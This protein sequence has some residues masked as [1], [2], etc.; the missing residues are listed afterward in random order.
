MGNFVNVFFVVFAVLLWLLIIIRLIYT[1]FAKVKSVNAK[2][3]DKYKTSSHSFYP[4]TFKPSLYKV[5]FKANNKTVSFYVSEFSFNNYKINEK[6]E[7]KYKG[8][9][10]ISFK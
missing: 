7:L 4:K 10:L 3:V 1:K 2:V 8:S 5:V 9:K 6:G